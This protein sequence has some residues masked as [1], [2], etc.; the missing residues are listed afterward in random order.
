MD[1]ACKI[2]RHHQQPSHIVLLYGTAWVFFHTGSIPKLN[3]PCKP[4]GRNSWAAVSCGQNLREWSLLNERTM[5]VES[6][7]KEKGEL[8]PASS[9]SGFETLSAK[10]KAWE[11]KLPSSSP[12][13]T[14]FQTS[15]SNHSR[16]PACLEGYK[17]V[18]DGYSFCLEFSYYLH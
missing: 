9:H 15:L 12:P 14:S 1:L 13:K 17:P 11:Q 16:R 2:F 7:W 18:G 4:R 5:E 3:S 8:Q 6:R 10:R